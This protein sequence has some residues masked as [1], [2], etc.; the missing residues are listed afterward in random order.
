MSVKGSTPR[1]L[2]VPKETFDQ[3]FE[4]IFGKKLTRIESDRYEKLEREHMGD[5]EKQTGIYAGDKK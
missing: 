4:R 1:P 3:S 5:A 2:S